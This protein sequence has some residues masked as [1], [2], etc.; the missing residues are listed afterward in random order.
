MK[1]IKVI[2]IF[3]LYHEFEKRVNNFC[4]SENVFATQTHVLMVE[5]Q[6][7]YVAVLFYGDNLK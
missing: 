3:N 6:V 7:C 2:Q 4:E 5:K 1:K